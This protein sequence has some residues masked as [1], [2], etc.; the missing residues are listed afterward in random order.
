M[1]TNIIYNQATIIWPIIEGYGKLTCDG[2]WGCAGVN[3]P[4]KPNSTQPLN[5][6]SDN[7]EIHQGHVY[8]PEYA[9]CNIH[10]ANYAGCRDVC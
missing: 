5:I 2:T 10:C 7:G 3:W 1:I 9:P 4:D 8:C 6:I